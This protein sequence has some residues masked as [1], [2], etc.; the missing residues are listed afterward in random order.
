M[1]NSE[2]RESFQI[3]ERK[4]RATVRNGKHCF[5]LSYFEGSESFSFLLCLLV[6]ID[7][8]ELKIS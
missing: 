7:I 5:N 8:Q 4:G 2:M 6:K 3:L 1:L